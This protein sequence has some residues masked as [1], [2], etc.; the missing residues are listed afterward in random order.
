MSSAS[1][2]SGVIAAPDKSS[3][4]TVAERGPDV[5]PFDLQATTHIFT[6]TKTG[7]IQQVVVKKAR[8]EAQIR[9][10]RIYF[11]EIAAQFSKGDFSGPTHIHGAGMPGLAE[12]KK[13]KPSEIKV[14][15]QAIDDGAKLVCTT[16]NR[17][18]VSALHKWFDTQ[19]SD[20]GQD[21]MEGH[22]HLMMPRQ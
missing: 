17:K 12:L 18:L 15:Y 21:A 11:Q 4:E 2:S 20:H 3:Q 14:Q 16:S 19:V 22:D 8:D 13:A 6:K 5:M 7:D 9:L 10:I 1:I